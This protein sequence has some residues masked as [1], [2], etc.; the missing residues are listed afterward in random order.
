MNPMD[1]YSVNEAN[2]QTYRL[3]C[4]VAQSAMLL[5]DAHLLTS[6]PLA[7]LLISLGGIAFI[8][9]IWSPVVTSRQ[10]VVDFY[11]RQAEGFILPDGVCTVRE[12]VQNTS[13]KRELVNQKYF[14]NTTNWRETRVK[15]DRWTPIFFTVLWLLLFVVG[16]VQLFK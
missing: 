8:W 7:A 5:V 11:K 4:L 16:F 3:Y 13:G 9:L 2:L 14:G 10:L 6:A 12:Y 1:A 15:I